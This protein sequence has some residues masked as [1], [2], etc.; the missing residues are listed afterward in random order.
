M[1]TTVFG[2]FLC[3]RFVTF[4]RILFRCVENL[5]RNGANASKRDKQGYSPVHYAAVRG[6]KLTLEM[7]RV[8]LLSYSRLLLVLLLLI[9]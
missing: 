7:V 9:F 5:L 8:I 4:C 2:M 3:L 6:H 1:R